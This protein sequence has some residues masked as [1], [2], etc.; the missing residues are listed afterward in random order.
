MIVVSLTS[1]TKYLEDRYGRFYGHTPDLEHPKTFNEK[2][3]FRMLN[4]KNK[5]YTQLA[6]KLRA[7]RFVA[8]SIGQQYVIPTFGIWRNIRDI[9]FEALPE[10][11]VLKCNHDSGSAVIC[12][13]K[14]LLDIKSVKGKLGYFLKR[15]MYYTRREQ[16]YKAIQ[17]KVFCE[18][19][20]DSM[21]YAIKHHAPELY[22]LHC[23]HGTVEYIEADVVD[24]KEKKY[25][26]VYNA[27]W[28]LLDVEV[29]GKKSLLN[30]IVP[31][32]INKLLE[33][34][35][36]LLSKFT[37]DYCRIDWFIVDDD[38][39]FNEFTFTPCAGVM[40]FSPPEFDAVFGEKW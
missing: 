27:D 29:D 13:S 21:G 22:R 8:E 3:L 17:S 34:N 33:L 9:P 16:H 39:Y 7:K 10:Q 28:E 40:K 35:Q 30:V 24:S 36:S 23:F 1:N 15:N 19:F 12:R 5:I 18:A 20:I 37:T 38:I 2:I 11:F 14:Q 26:N 31:E 4:D 6:D 25:T 32:T